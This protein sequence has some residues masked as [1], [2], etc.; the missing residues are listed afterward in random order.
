MYLGLR[1]QFQAGG[2]L[3]SKIA[4][5]RAR[6]LE[7]MALLRKE[8]E[9]LTQTVSAWVNAYQTRSLV[10]VYDRIHS[11]E[12]ASSHTCGAFLP[13]VRPGEMSLTRGKRSPTPVSRG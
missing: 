10:A 5:E 1:Y 13:A 6:Y 9:V 8:A 4:A 7:Q 12:F 3:E 2:E 11:L